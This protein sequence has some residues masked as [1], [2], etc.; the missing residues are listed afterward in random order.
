MLDSS[1]Q[2]PQKGG[3]VCSANLTRLQDVG[4]LDQGIRAKMVN[5]I[6]P[7]FNTSYSEDLSCHRIRVLPAHQSRGSHLKSCTAKGNHYYPAVGFG[8]KDKRGSTK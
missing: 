4:S 5:P 8:R 7:V 6:C 3:N 1:Q 2:T